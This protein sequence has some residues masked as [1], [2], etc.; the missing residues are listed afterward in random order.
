MHRLF[1]LVLGLLVFCLAP[2]AYADVATPGMRHVEYTFAIDN[3]A[4]HK[5]WVFVAYPWTLSNGVPKKEFGVVTAE[6]L[7]IGRWHDPN[8]YAVKKADFDEKKLKAMKEDDLEK[9]F[10]KN[11]KVLD[12]KIK[13]EPIRQ[14]K[15]ESPLEKVHDVIHVTKLDAKGFEAK[16]TK[17]SYKAKD[18]KSEDLEY[19]DGKR[20][21]TTFVATPAPPPTPTKTTADTTPPPQ[22]DV[23]IENPAPAPPP[24]AP[25]QGGCG[26]T[27]TPSSGSAYLVLLVGGFFALQAWRR[28]N[29]D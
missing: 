2:A 20:P 19:K 3:A 13:V 8:I 23:K 28:R 12:S 21:D 24:V 15:D 6:G 18:G 25:K 7:G 4:E 5:D 26:C 27:L 1:L 9:F 29:R 11:P 16:L 14:V 17:V 10:T 22:G